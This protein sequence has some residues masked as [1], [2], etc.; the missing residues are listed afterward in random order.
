MNL[1]HSELPVILP[2]AQHRLFFSVLDAKA[3]VDSYSSYRTLLECPL[4]S[5]ASLGAPSILP[6]IAT[7]LCC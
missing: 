5:E 6:T 1:T 7:P 2:R 4:S 3:T